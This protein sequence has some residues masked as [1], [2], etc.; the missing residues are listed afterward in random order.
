M[1]C[2]TCRKLLGDAQLIYE[3]VFD[4]ICKDEDLKK[5]TN[6]EAK[7]LKTELIL[8]FDMKDRFCCRP[9]FMTYKRLIDIIK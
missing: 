4:E 8:A 1:K 5:I 3:K 9:R 6:Q 2:P 7:R